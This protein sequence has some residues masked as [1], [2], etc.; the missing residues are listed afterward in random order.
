MKVEE[1]VRY[2]MKTQG[3]YLTDAHKLST[4]KPCVVAHGS[5]NPSTREAEGRGLW[6]WGQSV[7]HNKTLSQTKHH[8]QKFVKTEVRAR[9]IAQWSNTCL[10]RSRPWV[11]SLAP[12]HKKALKTWKKK[13]R[14]YKVSMLLHSEPVK[15]VARFEPIKKSLAFVER[16]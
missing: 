8:Y 13:S 16:M 4:V 11:W 7:M 14:S 5:R 6:D 12:P 2:W 1:F 3:L 9:G 10:W 15:Y